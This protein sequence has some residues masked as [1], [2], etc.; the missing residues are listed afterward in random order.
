MLS[1]LLRLVNARP[2]LRSPLLLR[3][4]VA[5]VPIVVTREER[6]DHVKRDADRRPESGQDTHLD[7]EGL[8]NQAV[9]VK[10]VGGHAD[11][12]EADAKRALRERLTRLR[13]MLRRLGLHVQEGQAKGL[14]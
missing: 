5:T 8:V 13:Q 12:E 2:L 9:A 7:R 10:E 1:L 14:V 11:G 4:T 6:Q 3:R